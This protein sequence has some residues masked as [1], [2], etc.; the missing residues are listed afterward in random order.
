[1]NKR[2]IEAFEKDEEYAITAI[3]D[4]PKGRKAAT[5]VA[6]DTPKGKKNTTIANFSFIFLKNESEKCTYTLN[7]S[8]NGTTSMTI[9]M[10]P[11]KK[12]R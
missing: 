9:I 7:V 10:N 6:K 2:I 5:K 1:M 3:K 12:G 4:M 8:A 11:K